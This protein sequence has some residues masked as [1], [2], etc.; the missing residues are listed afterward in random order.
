MKSEE[1]RKVEWTGRESSRGVLKKLKD[2]FYRSIYLFY[3]YDKAFENEDIKKE[4]R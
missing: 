1:E 4:G 2:T 3:R